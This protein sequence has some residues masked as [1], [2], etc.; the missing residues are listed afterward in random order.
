MSIS[1]S[2]MWKRFGRSKVE[3]DSKIEIQ[4]TTL[5][6]IYHVLCPEDVNLDIDKRGF[7]G[8]LLKFGEK[9]D[10]IS[11]LE[12]QN[13]RNMFSI[14]VTEKSFIITPIKSIRISK[15]DIKGFV[16]DEL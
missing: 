2:K 1:P 7:V 12:D 11:F 6:K 13:G 9:P 3:D 14:R 15:K 10:V 8:K 5:E 4:I 16:A